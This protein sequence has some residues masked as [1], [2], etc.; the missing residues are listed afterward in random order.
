M[1]TSNWIALGALGVSIVSVGFSIGAT[2]FSRPHIKARA[3]FWKEELDDE[4]SVGSGPPAGIQF[5]IKNHG[6]RPVFLQYLRFKY[7]GRSRDH[8]VD[9]TLDAEC[10]EKGRLKLDGEDSVTSFFDSGRDA[11]FKSQKGD[12]ARRV[13]V[14]DTLERRYRVAGAGRAIAEYFKANE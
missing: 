4:G 6:E 10:D 1:D 14:E 9:L 8:F 11:G 13:F 2:L 12:V 7:G 5:V 3:E